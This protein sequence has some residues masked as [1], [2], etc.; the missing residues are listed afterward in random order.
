VKLV[1]DTNVI[2][3]GIVAEGLCRE[4]VEL[5][6]PAHETVLSAPLFDELV[7]TLERKFDL[8]IDELP[9]V[10]FYRRNAT[11]VEAEELSPRVCRDRADDWVL[12]TA[13]AGG[14]EAIVT[15]DGDQLVLDAWRGIEMLTP[16]RFLERRLPPA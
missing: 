7:A 13:L 16:R 1:F 3:A 8:S 12:A 4:L 10:S 6:L 2:V 15:G 11:W 9:V 14:A 5:H